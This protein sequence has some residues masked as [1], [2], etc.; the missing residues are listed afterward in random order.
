MEQELINKL[1]NIGFTEGEAKTYIALLSVGTST[2]GPIIDK[3]GVSASKVYQILDRLMDKG[4][5]SMMVKKRAKHFTASAPSRILDYLEEE[6][7]RI[8]T[9]KGKIKE[10]LPVLNLKKDNTEKL[11]MVE[12]SKGRRGFE[13]LFKELNDSGKPGDSYCAIAGKAIS[14][15]LQSLWYHYSVIQS[16]KRIFQRIIYE[17]DV[18]Y[19]K[20]PTIHRRQERIHYY[21]KVLPEKYDDLPNFEVIGDKMMINSV[22]ESDD[23]F[24]IIIRD[25]VTV[26]AFMKVWELLNDLG[27]VPE[28]FKEYNSGKRKTKN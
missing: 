19:R 26:K 22:D 3:S 21:P 16:Q 8:D 24:S 7:K 15:R 23:I 9:N 11:P 13:A 1:V 25:K 6:K 4:L 18:W 12:F 27:G 10:I 17:H 14:F 5:V 20:D 28:G 2:V